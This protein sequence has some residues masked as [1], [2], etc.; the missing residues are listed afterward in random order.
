MKVSILFSAYGL[1]HQTMLSELQDSL[2]GVPLIGGSS[3]GEVSGDTGYT[4][5]GSVLMLIGADNIQCHCGVVDGLHGLD[6]EALFATVT[7]SVT[8]LDTAQPPALCLLFPDGWLPTDGQLVVDAFRNALPNVPLFGGGVCDNFN[9]SGTRQFFGD[10]V[11]SDAV[12]FM[13]L[14]G[15]LEFSYGLTD[16]LNGGWQPYGAL[17]EA[18]TKENKLLT[19]DGKPAMNYLHSDFQLSGGV[20]SVA[21]PVAIYESKEDEHFYYRDISG[22]DLEDGSLQLAQKIPERCYARVTE[23]RADRIL[24]GSTEASSRA[25]DIQSVSS[26]AFGLWVSCVSRAAVLGSRA[27][28]EFRMAS[29]LYDLLPLIGFYSYGEIAPRENG[30]GG[31]YHSTTQFLLLVAE[32]ETHNRFNTEPEGFESISRQRMQVVIE[33]QQQTIAALEIQIEQLGRQYN[34]SE[35]SSLELSDTLLQALLQLLGETHGRLPHAC[36][37][38]HPANLNRIGLARQLLKMVEKRQ[39]KLPWVGVDAISRHLAD[40]LKQR[41]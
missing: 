8:A 38:G 16:N 37:K 39:G 22:A 13:L 5:G 26:P 40:L 7:N 4:V 17:V 34:S 12:P 23:P 35:E 2:A 15:P 33:R 1:D 24:L 41:G 28:D 31:H 20:F 19:L 9:F 25:M 6:Q 3:Q 30:D 21:H 11:F 18:V 14:C 29:E 32:R 36:L 27:A 10:Q